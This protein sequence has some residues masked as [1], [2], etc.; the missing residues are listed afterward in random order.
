MR[1]TLDTCVLLAG[2]LNKRSWAG[3][4]SSITQHVSFHVTEL[5]YRETLDVI[6]RKAPANTPK[7]V[8]NCALRRVEEFIAE[9]ATH[10]TPSVHGPQSHRHV[11]IDALILDDAK[12]NKSTSLCTYNFRDFVGGGVAL[13]SPLTLVRTYVISLA[14]TLEV[15][16]PL[17]RDWTFLLSGKSF[18]P[19]SSGILL[20]DRDHN[21]IGFD[22][23]GRLSFWNSSKSGSPISTVCVPNTPGFTLVLRM[24]NGCEFQAHW[25]NDNSGYDISEDGPLVPS[26][27]LANTRLLCNPPFKPSPDWY[28]STIINRSA[29]QKFVAMKHLDNPVKNKTL[30]THSGSVALEALLRDLCVGFLNT[31]R[32][33][34][35]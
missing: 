10:V 29:I 32:Q 12:A 31:Y 9:L 6:L 30:E 35:C 7:M 23:S 27:Q 25:W 14:T 28:A 4:L 3:Q 26:V 20:L 13:V 18:S 5:V 15:I 19:H 17:I 34:D 21:K 2:A 16:P 11:S 8:R 1:V 22:D 24:K 33:R